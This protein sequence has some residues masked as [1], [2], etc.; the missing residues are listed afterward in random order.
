MGST[1]SP[2]TLRVSDLLSLAKESTSMA[3]RFCL[4]YEIVFF[5]KSLFERICWLKSF[6]VTYCSSAGEDSSAA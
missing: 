3:S 6:E 4:R 2:V 1:E 5:S